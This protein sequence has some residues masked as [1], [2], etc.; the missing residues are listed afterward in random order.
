MA[1]ERFRGVSDRRGDIY[2]LGATLYEL[3]TLR[4]LFE[5]CDPIGLIELIRN[6]SP[7]PP[8]HPGRDIPRNLETI[9][10]K[11]L[12]KD[13]KDRF[14][15][16]GELANELRRFVEGRPIR[17]RPVSIVEQFWRWCSASPGSLRR[18]SPRRCSSRF[19][20]WFRR[21]LLLS[22]ATRPGRS[23]SRPRRSRIRPGRSRT[24]AVARMRCHLTPGGARSTPTPRKP[25]AGRFSG[26]LGQ[27]FESL[28]AMRQATTLL[29]GLPQGS[30]AAARRDSLRNLAIT[31]M[32]LA[33]LRRITCFDCHAL[34]QRTQ[35]QLHVQGGA[36][37]YGH[38]E[39]G[40]LIGP[41][42]LLDDL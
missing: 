5:G 13:P 4:P 26:R 40:K 29:E 12:A 17:S 27:R 2:S 33:D 11:A 8:S 21:L 25:R 15:S 19:W 3:L 28:E 38:A 16:A 10:L 18:I 9:V 42:P 30:A 23:R 1:P 37:L 7:A 31:C 32:T 22:T 39:V 41:E 14:G 6:T 35:L 34:G 24:S 36:L 20:R